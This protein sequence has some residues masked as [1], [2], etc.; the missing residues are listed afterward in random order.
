MVSFYVNVETF[1][2]IGHFIFLE[3]SVIR[4]VSCHAA[5]ATLNS[6]FCLILL[7]GKTQDIYHH[8]WPFL[9]F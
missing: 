2:Y 8:M 9:C 7:S 3:V 1:M 4:K 5:Q 6:Q